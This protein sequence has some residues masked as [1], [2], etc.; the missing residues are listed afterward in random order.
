[1]SRNTA[2]AASNLRRMRRLA[3]RRREPATAFVRASLH[4]ASQAQVYSV[5][6][7]KIS[8]VVNLCHWKLPL[9]F[10]KHIP[11]FAPILVRLSEYLY[12]LYHF[13]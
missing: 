2:S 9:L 12:E 7:K 6:L 5:S 11:T 8:L 1:M 13:Y 3:N 10:S 4:H